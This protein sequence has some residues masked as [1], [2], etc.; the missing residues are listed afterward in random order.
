MHV[1][2]VLQITKVVA[3]SPSGFQYDSKNVADEEIKVAWNKSKSIEA[4]YM[5]IHTQWKRLGKPMML[6]QNF[7]LVLLLLLS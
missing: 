4:S 2:Y 6:L 7:L 3:R 5:Y 1:N